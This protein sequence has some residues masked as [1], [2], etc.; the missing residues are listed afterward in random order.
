MVMITKSTGHS[1]TRAKV[2]PIYN[3]HDQNDYFV[4]IKK[5]DFHQNDD[6]DASLLQHPNQRQ[7]IVRTRYLY[8]IEVG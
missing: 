4:M 5:S 7:H 3:N 8:V 2:M 1:L 6:L